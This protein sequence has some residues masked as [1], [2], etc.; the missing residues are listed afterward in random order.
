MTAVGYLST[1]RREQI[2]SRDGS[3]IVVQSPLRWYNRTGQTRT[4]HGAW[5]AAG[6]PPT[7]QDLIVDI[8]RNGATIY[9]TQANRPRV[10]AGSNGG[11]IS[12]PNV[13]LL[14][15]GDY[16]TVDIDQ[17]GSGVAGSDVTVGVVVS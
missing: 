7:G 10:V 6:T 2:W 1:A 12:A 9:T 14:A 3:A 13:V 11:V 5:V 8:N 4:I 17:I 16:L 15:D